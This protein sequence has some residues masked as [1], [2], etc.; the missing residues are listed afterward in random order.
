[1]QRVFLKFNL[2]FLVLIS[3]K[4][5]ITPGQG[6]CEGNWTW[7]NLWNLSTINIKDKSSHISIEWPWL[8][9]K[10]IS[11]NVWEKFSNLHCWNYWKMHL[12]NPL[13]HDL[14]TKPHVEQPPPPHKFVQESLSPPWKAFWKKVPPYVMGVEG[15]Q[16][17]HFL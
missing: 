8:Y 15:R 5:F 14:I 12:W 2:P 13:Y 3:Q 16:H 17:D 4:F 9:L 10:W 7:H 6:Q 1:M 11:H